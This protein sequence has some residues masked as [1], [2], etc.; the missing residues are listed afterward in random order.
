[1]KKTLKAIWKQIL[2]AGR[3]NY[4]AEYGPIKNRSDRRREERRKKK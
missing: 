1:M 3:N 2:Q 4:E